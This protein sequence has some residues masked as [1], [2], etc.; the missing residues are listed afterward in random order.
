M[1]TL[2]TLF[3]LLTVLV[4]ILPDKVN[5]DAVA[6]IRFVKRGAPAQQLAP[7]VKSG[8]PQQVA[9]PAPKEE[10]GEDAESKPNSTINITPQ[11][12]KD[13]RI[14]VEA[15]VRLVNGLR[16]NGAI[17]LPDPLE[18]LMKEIAEDFDKVQDALKIDLNIDTGNLLNSGGK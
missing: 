17:R 11:S 9:P 4:C 12:E 1:K 8:S 7:V 14:M 10:E 3:F 16:N 13:L 18:R 5:S 15:F 2:F 6:P